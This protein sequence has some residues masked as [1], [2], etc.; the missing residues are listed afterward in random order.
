MEELSVFGALGARLGL[1]LHY[2][3]V[4]AHAG[5]TL[6]LEPLNLTPV[7]ATAIVY[8]GEHDGCDQMALG[9]ALG[10]NRPRA[11]KIV[12]ELEARGAVERRSGRDRRSNA[13][14]LT[15]HGAELRALIEAVTIEHDEAVFGDL[16][17]DERTELRR[18][19]LKLRPYAAA[20][21]QPE[22]VA[23]P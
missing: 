10:V 23:A 15:P 16:T 17:P 5:L 2:A 18:L 8:V 20:S 9:R 4:N 12:D 13:L 14:H 1:L 11:M 7:R 22:L 3:D 6:R 21:L 19:L